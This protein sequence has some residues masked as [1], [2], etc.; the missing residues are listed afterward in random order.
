VNATKTKT[1]VDYIRNL[2]PTIEIGGVNEN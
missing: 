2:I 1:I